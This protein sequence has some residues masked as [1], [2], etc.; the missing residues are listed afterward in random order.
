MKN[1]K[2]VKVVLI[3]L[4]GFI[5]LLCSKSA[6]AANN[7]TDLTDTLNN[8]SSATLNEVNNTS[9][10]N[11][12]KNTTNNTVNNVLKTNNTS[13]YNNSALPSTG[14]ESSMPAIV[15]TVVF[16]ISAVYAYKKVQEYRNI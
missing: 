15:L 12:T 2:V 5:I 10:N 1:S 11:T 8:T 13:N 6:I 3:M 4:I 9:G 7:F 14:L 16:A